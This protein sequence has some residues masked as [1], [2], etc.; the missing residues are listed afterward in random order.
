MGKKTTGR[1]AGLAALA[2]AAYMANKGKGESASGPKVTTTPEIAPAPVAKE[3]DNITVSGEGGFDTPADMSSISRVGTPARVASSVKNPIAKPAVAPAS[4]QTQRFAPIGSPVLSD[5]PKKIGNA[6]AVV[7][8][9]G[10]RS[11]RSDMLQNAAVKRAEN[12]M[13]P[14]TGR[15]MTVE[16]Y[17]ASGKAKIDK[18]EEL[19]KRGGA[20]KKMASGGMTSKRGDGIASKGK[21]RCKIC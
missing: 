7:A 20:V 5:N 11:V 15:K 8:Q 12:S 17:L 21:T 9:G 19:F 3:A 6:K 13:V 18:D 10:N 14:N 16:D 2:A 1:L 4:S